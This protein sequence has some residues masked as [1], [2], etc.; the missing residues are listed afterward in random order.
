MNPVFKTGKL[1]LIDKT[2]EIA[3]RCHHCGKLEKSKINIFQLNNNYYNLACSCN[4][5]KAKIKEKGD[6][7]IQFKY[8]CFLCDVYHQMVIKKDE[9][10]SNQSVKE[11]KCL[12]T[13]LE[14]GYYGSELLINKELDRQKEELKSLADELGINEYKEP[15]LLLEIFNIVHDRASLSKLYCEC[16][17]DKIDVRLYSSKIELK[18]RR[19]KST[20]NISAETEEQLNEIKE[21]GDIIIKNI[22]SSVDGWTDNKYKGE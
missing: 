10:W 20:L 14:M 13:G 22:N 21:K 9:F 18:C 2:I 12:N 19:C 6:K 17:S 1:M 8:Y 4:T 11:I 7:Y 16:G 5:I 15:E 3:F